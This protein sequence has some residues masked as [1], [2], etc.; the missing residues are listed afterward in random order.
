MRQEPERKGTQITVVEHQSVVEQQSPRNNGL[1]LFGATCFYLSVAAQIIAS[2]PLAWRPCAH[3]V[4]KNCTHK[5]RKIFTSQ[6]DEKLE[7]G[8]RSMKRL[9]STVFI[10]ALQFQCQCMR[11]STDTNSSKTFYCTM[12]PITEHDAVNASKRFNDSSSQHWLL[13]SSL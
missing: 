5:R 4:I 1:Q 11:T 2:N 13:T 9:C 8:I 6:R 3:R 7:H 10:H 12:G